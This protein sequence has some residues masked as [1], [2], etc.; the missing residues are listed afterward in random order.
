MG[1]APP[2]PGAAGRR[3]VPLAVCVRKRGG[4][5]AI[6]DGAEQAGRQRV[7]EEAVME[8][9]GGGGGGGITEE[10]TIRTGDETEDKDTNK[11]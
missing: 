1:W 4:A 5:C 8:E 2:D 10:E 9:G 11:T 3:N 6:K 7:E